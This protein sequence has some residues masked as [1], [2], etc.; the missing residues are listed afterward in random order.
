MNR[1][2]AHAR[3]LAAAGRISL[4]LGLMPGLFGCAEDAPDRERVRDDDATAVDADPE[5]LADGGQSELFVDARVSPDAL[6]P[7][8]VLADSG[9]PA[10]LDGALPDGGVGDGALG[11]AGPAC[12]MGTEEWAACCEA[13]NWAATGCLAWGP[14]VPPALA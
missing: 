13:S 5:P 10:L 1:T 6:D 3:A 7:D 14:P 9:E 11:D 2:E 12:P 8:P 4:V